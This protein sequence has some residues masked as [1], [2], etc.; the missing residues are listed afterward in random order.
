M[1]EYKKRKN[2]ISVL[3]RNISKSR[4]KEGWLKNKGK[5]QPSKLIIHNLVIN[6]AKVS[7]F[8][9]GMAIKPIPFELSNIH[10]NDLGL[11]QRGIG[12]EKIIELLLQNIQ[13]QITQKIQN[14]GKK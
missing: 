5:S 13:L 3:Q 7:W 6:N 2:N 4:Q 8:P 14:H 11:K 9:N 12:G 1:Y 10:L